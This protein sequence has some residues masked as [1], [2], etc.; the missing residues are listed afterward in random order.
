[1]YRFSILQENNPQ[2]FIVSIRNLR[3]SSYPTI[4]LHLF[5]VWMVD[6]V[7]NPF[8]FNVFSVMT[9]S[10]VQKILGKFHDTIWLLAGVYACASLHYRKVL[11]FSYPLLSGKSRNCHPWT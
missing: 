9:L 7:L 6:R 4:G 10:C 2:I 11:C 5:P 3:P 1:M 8:E